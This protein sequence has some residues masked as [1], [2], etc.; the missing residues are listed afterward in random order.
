[1]ISK[2]EILIFFSYLN[3]FY[4]VILLDDFFFYIM[5][6]EVKDKNETIFRYVSIYIRKRSGP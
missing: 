5:R 1:M 4:K 3:P 6:Q 2:Y